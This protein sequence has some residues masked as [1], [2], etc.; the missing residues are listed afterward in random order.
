VETGGCAGTKASASRR[1][2]VAKAKR[3]GLKV[4]DAERLRHLEEENRK[5]RQCSPGR[6]RTS[7]LQGKAVLANKWQAERRRRRLL[8]YREATE[9][10]ERRVCMQMEIERT[11]VL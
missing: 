2:I 11:V 8:R 1:S 7:C 3:G 4:S 5:P 10:S 9:C 6:R